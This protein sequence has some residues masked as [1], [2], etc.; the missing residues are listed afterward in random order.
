MLTYYKL[1]YIC[2]IRK[3]GFKHVGLVGDYY[4]Y[5]DN[6]DFTDWLEYFAL[7]VL[8]ELSR[9]EKNILAIK[10]T[11]PTPAHYQVVLNYLA[12]HHHISQKEYAKISPR[13]LAARKKDFTK[14]QELGLIEIKEGG[15]NTYYVVK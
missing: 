6:V 11:I 9:V 7:G 15:R 4:D 5:Q 14:M 1:C 8:D 2:K 10:N 13:S 12:E 3:F